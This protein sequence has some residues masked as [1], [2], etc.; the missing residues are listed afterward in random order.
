MSREAHIKILRN[1]I[2]EEILLAFKLP[3]NEF[4]RKITSP[5]F[6]KPAEKFARIGA[7][8][9]YDVKEFGVRKAAELML[10]NFV[11][12]VSSIGQNKV[13]KEGPLLVVSNHPG[14]VDSVAIAASLPRNDL[15]IVAQN[16][17]FLMDLPNA[18]KHL[19]YT[20]KPP[21]IESR[22]AVVRSSIS[23]LRSGGAVL[24]FPSGQIDPDPA[25]LPKA[26]EAIEKWSRSIALMLRQAPETNTLV[27]IVSGVLE[28][29]YA[30]NPFVK[31]HRDPVAQRRMA[32]FIQM[33]QQLFKDRKLPQANISFG[34]PISCSCFENLRDTR[35][36][37]KCIK[38]Q[39]LELLDEHMIRVGNP[40]QL[41]G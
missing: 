19:I 33:L 11:D 30:N 35:E 25:V 24:I 17:P 34:D 18:S 15:K 7:N 8:L 29:K 39:A 31:I 21:H 41:E 3:R 1:K 13:P 38:L 37:I 2:Y 9:D 26:R 28:K 32:E 23:H 20:K 10:A 4:S 40:L 14:T 6:N 27:T 36:V 22:A 5:L 16:I 12:K